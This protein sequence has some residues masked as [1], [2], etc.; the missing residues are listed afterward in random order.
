M[1]QRNQ[2]GGKPM[3]TRRFAYTCSLAST[4]AVLLA[5]VAT[6][7]LAPAQTRGPTDPGVRAGTAGA[8]SPV[9]GLSGTETDFFNAAADVFGETEDV[10]AG[11]GPRFNLDSCGGC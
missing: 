6:T 3:A 2:I 11:L 9:A 7:T 4:A 10:A 5:S 1:K 8:G